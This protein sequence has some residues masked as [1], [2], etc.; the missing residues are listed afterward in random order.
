MLLSDKPDGPGGYK[1]VAEMATTTPMAAR[2]FRQPPNFILTLRWLKYVRTRSSG[3]SHSVGCVLGI[4]YRRDC[5]TRRVP[6]PIVEWVLYLV[7]PRS[8]SPVLRVS[9]TCWRHRG[10]HVAKLHKAR[11]SELLS[12]VPIVPSP[13]AWKL[14]LIRTSLS[15]AAGI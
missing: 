3:T 14:S 12:R 11:F 9:S 8:R 15:R 1:G 4:P 5:G 6:R 7:S 10:K 2:R 13:T